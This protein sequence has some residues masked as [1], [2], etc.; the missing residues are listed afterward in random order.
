MFCGLPRPD[1]LAMTEGLHCLM[2]CHETQSVSRNDGREEALA[3]Q[4]LR[5]SSE[6][7]QII[8]KGG[9]QGPSLV[10]LKSATGKPQKNGLRP[11]AGLKL[12]RDFV[13][14]STGRRSRI[15]TIRCR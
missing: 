4:R 2:D 3:G 10:K 9:V 14:K 1:G 15:P 8:K 11:C 13:I 5:S 7:Q 6:W 12:E